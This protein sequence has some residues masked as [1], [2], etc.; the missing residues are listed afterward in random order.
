MDVRA[1]VQLGQKNS[2]IVNET[3]MQ[4]TRLQLIADSNIIIIF[5][6]LGLFILIA[7]TTILVHLKYRKNY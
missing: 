3:Y 1:W 7:V 2:L 6:C 4:N 5:A